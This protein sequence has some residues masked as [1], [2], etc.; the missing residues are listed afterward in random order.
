MAK[1]HKKS[2]IK[3]FTMLGVCIAVFSFMTFMTDVPV[4]QNDEPVISEQRNVEAETE[5]IFIEPQEPEVYE[6]ISVEEEHEEEYVFV[7]S[8]PIEGDIIEEFSGD[9]LVYSRTLDDWRVHNGIDIKGELL[10]RVYASE[11]GIVESVYEDALMGK[12]IIIDHQNGFKTVYSNLSST[13]MADNGEF[14]EKGTII[15]GVGNS[16]LAESS[17]EP[18]IHFQV[19]KDGVT[20]N[21]EDFIK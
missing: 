21:P 16:A 11:R 4:P 6:E 19:I 18:H 7:L 2:K 10:E 15:S 13:E 14:V 3:A 9:E 20:V 1:K 17:Q 12:T 5:M 8:Y